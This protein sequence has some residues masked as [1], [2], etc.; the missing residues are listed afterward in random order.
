MA[1]RLMEKHHIPYFS[2]DHLKMGLIRSENSVLTPESD[3]K[4]LMDL[5]WPIVR[6]MIK[7]AIENRQSM[8]IEGCYIP[9]DWAKDFGKEYLPH[10][11]YICLVMSEAY[12]RAHFDSIRSH[13]CDIESRLDDSELSISSVLNDNLK[14]L[15]MGRAHG[16]PCHL[17]DK[18]YPEIIEI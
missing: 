2:L 18:T 17:I 1:Q 7:T 5:L 15:E 14:F 12:I 4:A 11:K 9:C 8:I 10:I 16:L 6:E 3:E 13:A